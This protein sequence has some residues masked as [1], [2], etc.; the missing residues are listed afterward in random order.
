MENTRNPSPTLLLLDSVVIKS[1]LEFLDTDSHILSSC[2]FLWVGK[3]AWSLVPAH[4]LSQSLP[5]GECKL[6]PRSGVVRLPCR[7]GDSQAEFW[8]IRGCLPGR[9]EQKQNR[10]NSMLE[11]MEAGRKGQIPYDTA[12]M[13]NPKKDTNELIYK[14]RIDPQT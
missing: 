13:W 10:R 1:L 5:R 8:G 4:S 6:R 3:T 11:G 12:Y 9:N 7:W 14:T 2:H